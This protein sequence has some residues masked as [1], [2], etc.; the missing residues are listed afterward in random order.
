MKEFLK[1]INEVKDIDLILSEINSKDDIIIDEFKH[2]IN[3]EI[4]CNH[5]IW[6]YAG[7]YSIDS[8][9]YTNSSNPKY[10]LCYD[11]NS[12]RFIFNKY[13]C[14]GCGSII[15]PK[16]Y[17]RFEKTHCVLKNYIDLDI[18]KYTELYYRLL[19]SFSLEES[20]FILMDEFNY[21]K[22]KTKKKILEK[23]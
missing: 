21:N 18:Q 13:I 3:Y 14:L 5:D 23:N 19:C 10:S 1:L 9:K 16:N 17:L 12:K 8:S 22:D 11:E 7:S 2:A 6:M 20:K 4:E 15:K